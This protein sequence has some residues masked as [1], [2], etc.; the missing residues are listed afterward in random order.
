MHDHHNTWHMSET[1]KHAIQDL[2]KKEFNQSHVQVQVAL[3]AQDSDW[4]VWFRDPGNQTQE[5]IIKDLQDWSPLWDVIMQI[6][7]TY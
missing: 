7:L 6:K 1:I 3:D 5:V 2:L 4:H